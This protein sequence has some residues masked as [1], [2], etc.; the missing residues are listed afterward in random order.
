MSPPARAGLPTLI[1]GGAGFIGSN[2]AASLL[3]DGEHVLVYDNL[4]RPG[5]AHNLR[6]LRARFGDALEAVEAD[7]RDRAALADAVARC[8]RVFHLAAQVAVTTSLDDPRED[9]EINLQ[10]TF[11]LL[12]A[13]RRT[14]RPVPLVFTSTNKVYGAIDDIPL[15]RA[16]L[17]GAHSRWQP[18]DPALRARGIDESRPLDFHSPYGCSK[19]AADQYVLD[20]ARSYGLPA[21]VLRMSCIYGPHQF[22]TEDQGWVAHFL[23]KALRGEPITLYGDGLQVRDVLFVDDLVRALRVLSASLP[24]ARPRAFN[25]GGGAENAI[26]LVEL[27]ERI[28]RLGG[29]RPRTIAADWRT[30]DQRWYV[31]DTTAA[32]LQLGWAPLVDA[33]EGLRRLH[34]WLHTREGAP[35]LAGAL[36]DVSAPAAT[37]VA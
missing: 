18:V 16:P 32:R 17:E 2:L 26:S 3:A 21:A 12:E 35:A 9:F 14:K 29:R 27:L 22:G 4:S 6:W 7:A 20:H 37:E 15:E 1:T 28:A 34:A 23:I 33:D 36:S 8:G 25:L 31:S 11:N 13:L 10:G 19:G 5:V 30:G 24:L